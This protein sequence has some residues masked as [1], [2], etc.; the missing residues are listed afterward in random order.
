M[1]K[2][3][4]VRTAVSAF[5]CLSPILLYRG[6]PNGTVIKP[7]DTDLI[8]GLGISPG[9]GNGNPLQFSCLENSMD[10]RA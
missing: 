8:P 4:A 2:W 9:G 1:G 5:H 6:F 10:R 3:M 7:G